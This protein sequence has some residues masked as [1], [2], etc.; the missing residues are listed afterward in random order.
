MKY[1]KDGK[2]VNGNTI[3]IVNMTYQGKPVADNQDF[4]V[5]QITIVE[6]AKRSQV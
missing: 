5:L 3:R 2:V 1:D 4:I 6:V